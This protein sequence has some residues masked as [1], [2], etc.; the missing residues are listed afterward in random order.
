MIKWLNSLPLVNPLGGIVTQQT[1]YLIG[2]D[3]DWELAIYVQQV[4]QYKKA[5]QL[6]V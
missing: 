1:M 6:M 2:L 3:N 5:C 4:V